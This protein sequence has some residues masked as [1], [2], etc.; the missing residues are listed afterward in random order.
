MKL[1]SVNHIGI[2]GAGM[3]G[4]SLAVLATGHGYRTTCVDAARR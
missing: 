3:I 1:D 4:N 2:I